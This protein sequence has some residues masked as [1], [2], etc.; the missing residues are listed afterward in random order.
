[1]PSNFASDDNA[2]P[3]PHPLPSSSPRPHSSPPTPSIPTSPHGQS[4]EDA[5][6]LPT[7]SM[8][9]SD[10]SPLLRTLPTILIAACSP[11]SP[12]RSPPC[13]LLT[14]HSS[15]PSALTLASALCAIGRLDPSPRL[16]CMHPQRR[17]SPPGRRRWTYIAPISKT[18]ALP[19]AAT[20]TDYV[21]IP[22]SQSGAALGGQ[23]RA[24]HPHEA[25][26]CFLHTALAAV[27]I[28]ASTGTLGLCPPPLSHK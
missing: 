28:T 18:G 1:M 4:D 8:E 26:G 10:I 11:P 6:A 17:S 24:E 15:A 14:L 7:V 25:T 20:S 5:A 9:I 13:S 22:V 19:D 3:L 23:R 12:A 27:S 16:I 21:P 2:A